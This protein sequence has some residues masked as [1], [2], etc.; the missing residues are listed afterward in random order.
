MAKVTVNVSMDDLFERTGATAIVGPPHDGSDGRAW[1][2]YRPGEVGCI[3]DTLEDAVELLHDEGI[4]TRPEPVL[5]LVRAALG[6]DHIFDSVEEKGAALLA[7]RTALLGLP[8]RLLK[9]AR[10]E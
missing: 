1:I 6:M 9:A 7:L 8:K 4:G 3:C 2:A 5:A 10:R